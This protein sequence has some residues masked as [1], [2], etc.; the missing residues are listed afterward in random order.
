MRYRLRTLLIFLAIGPMLLA[1]MFFL[2]TSPT[3][4]SLRFA[5]LDLIAFAVFFG[6]LACLWIYWPTLTKW[7]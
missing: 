3:Y 4:L 2:L 5:L 1:G 6:G 7:I